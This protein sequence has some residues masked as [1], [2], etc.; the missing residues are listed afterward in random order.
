MYWRTKGGGGVIPK[1]PSSSQKIHRKLSAK[2]E[3]GILIFGLCNNPSSWPELWSRYTYS[4]G[5]S[6][7]IRIH[8][9]FFLILATGPVQSVKVLPLGNSAFLFTWKAPHD[10]KNPIK[11]YRIKYGESTG[12]LLDENNYFRN[13]FTDSTQA[14]ISKLSPNRN[15]TCFIIPRTESGSGTE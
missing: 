14:K 3:S 8:Q 1:P 6:N 12:N 2:K 13:T 5:Q 15:Y 11:D 7:I 4:T 9:T 10:S